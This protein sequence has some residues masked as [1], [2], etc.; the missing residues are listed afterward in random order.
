MKSSNFRAT[1]FSSVAGITLGLMIFLSFGYAQ[2]ATATD[3]WCPNEPAGCASLGCQSNSAGQ[4]HCSYF[5]Q[6][7]GGGSCGRGECAVAPKSDGG[8]IG[9]DEGVGG[10]D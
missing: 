4:R 1:I 10:A 3:Y 6:T 8:E 9:I 5:Y 7:G 2:P